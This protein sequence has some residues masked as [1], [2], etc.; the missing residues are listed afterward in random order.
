MAV[1]AYNRSWA[2]LLATLYSNTFS[3][4]NP[5]GS[6]QTTL[7]FYTTFASV[8]NPINELYVGIFVHAVEYFKN[9]VDLTQMDFDNS[10]VHI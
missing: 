2:T 8:F 1:P 9:T 6:G 4:Y 10:G 3:F 5:F 7:L